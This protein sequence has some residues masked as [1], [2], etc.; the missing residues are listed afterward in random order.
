MA[1]RLKAAVL[2]LFILV[3]VAG[4]GIPTPPVDVAKETALIRSVVSNW[5]AAVEGYDV[6]GMLAPLTNSFVLTLE[7]GGNRTTKTIDQLSQELL[8]DKENQDY[9]RLN[10][11]YGLDLVIECF[12]VENLG[13]TSAHVVNRFSVYEWA[14]GTTP[15]I[16]KRITDKGAME[17]DL[18]KVS[19]KWLVS[20]ML[21]YFEP[22]G[23]SALD[24]RAAG[25]DG[26]G[27]CAFFDVE[28]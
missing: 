7:E 22:L 24:A 15:P 2:A 4:C 10:Y 9:W 5:E 20:G 1:G 26:P 23:P 19:G 16:G 27:K 18:I 6:D 3:T 17:W 8:G 13:H 25:Q 28:R 11:G 14:T 21:I 12:V